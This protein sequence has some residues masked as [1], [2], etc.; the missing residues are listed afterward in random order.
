MKNL[1]TVVDQLKGERVGLLVQVKKID[2]ALSA[3]GSVSVGTHGSGTRKPMS[4]EAKAR[5]RAGILKA[6]AAKKKAAKKST[7]SGKKPAPV[8]TG[9]SQPAA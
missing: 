3:L 4:P 7:K 9:A 8:Q 1:Q 2:A 5:I 6:I